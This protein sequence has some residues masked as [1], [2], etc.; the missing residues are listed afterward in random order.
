MLKIKRDTNQQYFKI[1]GYSFILSNLKVV[2]LV[3][4]TQ[5]N[6]GENSN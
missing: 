5:L 4:E 1:V 2:D 3:S 6:V